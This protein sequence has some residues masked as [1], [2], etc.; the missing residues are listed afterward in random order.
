MCVCVRV[1][2]CVCVCVSI[3]VISVYINV[4][5]VVMFILIVELIL[6]GIN[7]SYALMKNE[8]VEEK[9]FKDDSIY[10]LQ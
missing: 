8:I 2:V 3:C 10:M 5:S 6:A 1:C 4:I 9:Y 7:I